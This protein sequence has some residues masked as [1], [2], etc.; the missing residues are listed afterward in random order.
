MFKHKK[1]VMQCSIET[2]VSNQILNMSIYSLFHTCGAASRAAAAPWEEKV[3]LTALRSPPLSPP[4]LL[5]REEVKCT[6]SNKHTRMPM[7]NTLPSLLATAIF[8]K[9]MSSRAPEASLS[10]ELL[11]VKW[12]DDRAGKYISVRRIRCA[13]PW[14]HLM[15][16]PPN[17]FFLVC[18]EKRENIQQGYHQRLYATKLV[19]IQLHRKG[20]FRPSEISLSD[21][22]F[23]HRNMKLFFF[24]LNVYMLSLFMSQGVTHKFFNEIFCCCWKNNQ[25]KNI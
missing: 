3:W 10:L 8:L 24:C 13:P 23:T 21:S 12:T 1:T 11:G 17:V 5:E 2:K 22:T 6:P 7:Q 19:G 4:S 9:L 25:T 18:F 20:H 15:P 14:T 16:Q